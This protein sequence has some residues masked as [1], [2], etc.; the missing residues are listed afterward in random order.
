MTAAGRMLKAPVFVVRATP[1][2]VTIRTD[3]DE[4]PEYWHDLCLSHDDLVA[5]L[6]RIDLEREIAD[7][8]A[9]AN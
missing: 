2:G 4:N 1:D 5:M 9:T 6:A 7:Y 8:D 3:D